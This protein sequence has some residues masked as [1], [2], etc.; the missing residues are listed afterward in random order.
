MLQDLSVHRE[1]REVD[2]GTALYLYSPLLAF[3]LL[4]PMSLEGFGW[5]SVFHGL[6]PGLIP[7]LILNGVLAM[8][9]NFATVCALRYGSPSSYTLVTVLSS[10]ALFLSDSM[11]FG[12]S[13]SSAQW[14]G[15]MLA[16]GSAQV[17]A[18]APK[19]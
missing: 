12:T 3:M 7:Y 10:I 1:K 14:W 4:A 17:F 18:I 9:V 19:K 13:L 15:V 5:L 6:H 16:C 2:A 11:F 8:S